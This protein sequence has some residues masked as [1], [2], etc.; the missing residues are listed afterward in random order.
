MRVL[1]AG[2]RF[3]DDRETFFWEMTHSFEGWREC[4]II[5]GCAN[6]ADKLAIEFAE[7]YNLTCLKFPADWRRHGKSAGHIRNQQM[8]DEGKPDLVI[9]FPGGRGSKN[10]VSRSRKAGIKTLTPG[11]EVT[12]NA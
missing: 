2:G 3:F 8:L 12:E 11:W 4:T 10:M 5:S 1:V 9:V 6:G 7:I